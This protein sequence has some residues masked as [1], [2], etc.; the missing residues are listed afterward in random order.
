QQSTVNSQQSTVN[1]QQST[2]N[3]QQSTMTNGATGID[4]ILLHH[5]FSPHYKLYR[6]V[7]RTKVLKL[8]SY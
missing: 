2:V 6:F 7:V 8:R 3:S 4:I 1:S 5:N